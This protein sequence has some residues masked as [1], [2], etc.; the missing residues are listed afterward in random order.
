MKTETIMNLLLKMA[1]D[2]EPVGQARLAAAIVYKN[3]IVAF[4]TNKKKTH[5]FQRRFC[6]H[7]NAIN[8]HAETDAIKNALRDLSV[9]QLSRSS[10]Y[11]ARVR[12]ETSQIDLNKKFLRP[13]LAKPCVGCSRAISTFGIQKVCYSCDEGYDWL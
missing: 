9:D 7:E 11:V 4:G 2:V 5:P 1:R 3:D 10:L 6:K 8:L 12:Y 13:G